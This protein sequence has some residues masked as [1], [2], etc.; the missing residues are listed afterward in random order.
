MKR[1]NFLRFLA[2]GSGAWLLSGCTALQLKLLPVKGI[3]MNTSNWKTYCV[4]RYLI[5]IP[6]NASILKREALVW[7][8]DIIWRPDLTP[9][10]ARQ[11]A[12]KMMVKFQNRPH[13]RIAGG[14]QFIDKIEL[15]NGGTAIQAWSESSDDAISYV[16]AYM[17]TPENRI[18]YSAIKA[19]ANNLAKGHGLAMELAANIHAYD[20]TDPIPAMPGFCFKGGI[21]TQRGEPFRPEKAVLAFNLPQ[22]PT[23]YF[24]FITEALNFNNGTMLNKGIAGVRP[25]FTVVRRGGFTSHDLPAE[26]I[27]GLEDS[28]RN[29]GEYKRYFFDFYVP[30]V[31]F[32]LQRPNITFLMHNQENSDF[33]GHIFDSPEQALGLWEALTRSIRLRPGAV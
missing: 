8:N 10:S 7:G 29:D 17:I 3:V 11:E 16:H 19:F 5:D 23:L 26:E 18:F 1:R 21:N 24:A 30:S 2:S 14:T 15:P 32:S 31:A 6:P 20:D 25:S 12:E 9:Q 4:G 27:C 22:F 28:Y 13:K 33:S